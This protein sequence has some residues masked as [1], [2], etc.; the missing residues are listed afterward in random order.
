M[1][2]D[3]PLWFFCLVLIYSTPSAGS[4]VHSSAIGFIDG[5]KKMQRRL[6]LTAFN[7]I[8]LN[9][10]SVE[11]SAPL[12]ETAFVELH[13]TG[14]DPLNL[15]VRLLPPFTPATVNLKLTNI[16]KYYYFLH[17]YKKPS[18]WFQ[19]GTQLRIDTIMEDTFLIVSGEV[20][21]SQVTLIRSGITTNSHNITVL[22][23]DTP[24][25]FISSYLDNHLDDSGYRVIRVSLATFTGDLSRNPF[26]Y[27]QNSVI[28]HQVEV[29]DVSDTTSMNDVIFAVNL[30]KVTDSLFRNVSCSGHV[31]NAGIAQLLRLN[32]TDN[33]FLSQGAILTSIA[34]L[35]TSVIA[36]NVGPLLKTWSQLSVEYSN[37]TDNRASDGSVILN[38]WKSVT[39][40]QCQFT[41]NQ[42]PLISYLG[43]NQME[44]SDCGFTSNAVGSG[45]LIQ[46]D[47]VLIQRCQFEGS[48]A[49]VIVS[50]GRADIA[51]SSFKGGNAKILLVKLTTS[52]GSFTRSNF[53]FAKLSTGNVHA[54]ESNGTTSFLDCIIYGDYQSQAQSLVLLHAGA[55]SLYSTSFTISPNNSTRPSVDLDDPGSSLLTDN[56]DAYCRLM[57]SG[58]SSQV[59]LDNCGSTSQFSCGSPCSSSTTTSKVPIPYSVTGGP[60]GIP[61]EP[62][63]VTDSA[64]MTSSAAPTTSTTKLIP[65]Y[66]STTSTTS[67]TTSTTSSTTSTTSSTTSTTSSTTTR[68]FTSTYTSSTSSVASST[69]STPSTTVP[70]P[71]SPIS[72][73]QANQTIQ[74]IA[75]P[76]K[77]VSTEVIYN[78]V[79]QLF[80]NKTSS[81]P[82]SI[83]APSLSLTAY[84]TTR[85][86]LN[87]TSIVQ[88]QV[89]TSTNTTQGGDKITPATAS[90]SLSLLEDLK[91]T[92]AENQQTPPALVVFMEYAYNSGNFSVKAPENLSASIYGL[93]ITDANG[94]IVEVSDSKENIT[95]VIPTSGLTS[96]E[97]LDSV[98]CLY[99]SETN[100]FWSDDGCS[101]ERNYTSY[102]ITCNCNHLTNFTVGS[103]PV[104]PGNVAPDNGAASP[105][106]VPIIIGVVVGSVFLIAVLVVIVFILL[107][108]RR[109]AA[110][111]NM[112]NIPLDTMDASQFVTLEEKIGEGESSTIYRGLQSGTTHV[113]VKKTRSKDSKKLQNE[114]M[115][116]KYLSHF[117][118]NGGDTWIL[119]ELM[120]YNLRQKLVDANDFVISHRY[121][122]M[123]QI[124]RALSYLESAEIIH[125]DVAARNVLIKGNTAKLS[126]FGESMKANKKA[127]SRFISEQRWNAPEV[128]VKGEYSYASDIWSFGVLFWEV[129]SDGKEPYGAMTDQQ[130]REYVTGGGRLDNKG[131]E[132]HNSII[133]R[134]WKADAK[135]RMTSKDIVRELQ[136]HIESHHRKENLIPTKKE[137]NENLYSFSPDL[138]PHDYGM[139]Q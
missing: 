120:D 129:L 19:M 112:E 90:I 36:S 98:S 3:T 64:A 60:V 84:D 30:V 110:Q 57:T 105:S 76:N 121:D 138:R 104:R 128:M 102:V 68:S 70:P 74:H 61:S 92:R 73:G 71:P 115:N 124:A 82:I 43:S 62:S 97:Q 17:L 122:I 52:G 139:Y 63:S 37:F 75:A 65:T 23:G 116:L 28:L 95:I 5:G 100:H 80:S 35:D 11:I 31:I 137:T 106:M 48:S 109:S 14:Q 7:A 130:I 15:I 103:P 18:Q 6:I 46:A 12:F 59:Y 89:S 91:T 26:L 39:V 132:L 133:E 27:G 34:S 29:I 44:V 126:G 88:I 99:Y 93:T 20:I 123:L 33:T 42:Q 111:A 119:F 32:I 118:D 13:W 8:P 16:S 47:D 21:L 96:R 81:N 24:S 78:T 1:K 40:Y 51:D 50:A 107:K 127:V 2:M 25:Q 94:N 125:T 58:K 67:S 56:G 136:D 101:T 114:L 77:T 66:S 54:I 87:S 9:E 38:G 69:T 4:W 131:E 53:T 41:S 79:S 10:T 22:A 49:D 45:N 108:K 86:T 72:D 135:D 134:C 55:H 83:T 113:A 85:P 117:N